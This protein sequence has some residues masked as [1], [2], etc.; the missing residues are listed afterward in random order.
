MGEPDTANRAEG[1]LE[2]IADTALDD[3]YYVVRSGPGA[4]KRQFNTVLTGVV[5]AVF[6]LLVAVA[7]IQTRSD[8]PATERERAT[9]IDDVDARKETLADREATAVRLRA[10]VNALQ[11]QVDSFD[12]AYQELRLV[13]ADVGATGPG[14]TVRVTPNPNDDID[15]QI[16]DQDLRVLVNGLWYAGAEAV[17]ING[18]RI[19]TLSA[20]R[21]AESVIKVNYRGIAPPYVVE[22]IGDEDTMAERFEENPAGRY[23]V[24]RQQDAGVGFDVSRSSE[25]RVGV[26]PKP[27]LTIRHATAI[28]GEE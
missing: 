17:S 3:D 11:G 23:W 5:M 25:L 18:N 19:G 7:A 8:R 21:F 20:I 15:G 2:Q 9:L 12:P 6:A 26:V 10:E 1:L 13:A 22:A 27:R 16:R 24:K 28:K 4:Q 14:V